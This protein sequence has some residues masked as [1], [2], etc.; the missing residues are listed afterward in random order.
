M[1]LNLSHLLAVV[2]FILTLS[3]VSSASAQDGAPVNEYPELSPFQDPTLKEDKPLIYEPEGKSTQKE[4]T[5]N[6]T[7]TTSSSKP[8]AKTAEPSKTAASKNEEDALSFNF[9]YYIIQ[10]FKVSDIVDQ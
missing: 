2:T 9:L 4:Q 5:V 7:T 10:K 1:K 8:K 3:A 6:T